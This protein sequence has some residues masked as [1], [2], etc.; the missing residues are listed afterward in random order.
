MEELIDGQVSRERFL[1]VKLPSNAGT[2]FLELKA[3]ELNAARSSLAVAGTLLD[4][5]VVRLGSA[6]RL[7]FGV[8]FH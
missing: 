3:L 7:G 4:R 5:L 1:P 8:A 6:V 2:D